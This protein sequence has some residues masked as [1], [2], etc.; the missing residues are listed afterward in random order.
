MAEA[1]DLLAEGR[2]A[3]E[4]CEAAETEN[5]Q[6][7]RDDV[8]FA[9]E[10]KQWPDNIEKQRIAEGRPVI[11]VSKL[12]AFIRQVVNDARQNKPSVKVQPV[13]SGADIETA[14]VIAGLIRNIESVSNADI[15]YDTG[16]EC[17]VSRG[18]GYW[19]VTADH[20]YDD[21]FD[22]DLMIRRVPNPDTVYGDPSSTEADSSDWDTA[23]VVDW[24]KEAQF[25]RDWKGKNKTNFSADISQEQSWARDN[26]GKREIQV[27]EWWKR[28]KIDKP[29]VQVRDKRD[30]AIYVYGK[31]QLETDSDL[32]MLKQLGQLEF[33]NERVTKSCKVIQRFM[34][35][36]EILETKDWPGRYIPIV[37]VYG[38]D[39]VDSNGKRQLRGLIHSA[40]DAQRMFN[41]WRTTSTELVA[42]APR[43]PYIG[44]VG[45]FATDGRWDSV[46][47]TSHPYV[48]YDGLVAPQRQPLDTGAAAGALQEALNAADDIKA[49]IGM[50]DA[51][52]GARSNETSGKAIMA[53]QREGDVATFHFNDNTSRAIRHTGRIL[54]D[55][56]P[57]YYSAERVVRIL[58]EDGKEQAIQINKEFQKTDPRSGQPMM[59]PDGNGVMQPVMAMHDLRVGKY[60]VAVSQGPSFTTRR[61]EAAEAMT[62]MIRA[63]PQSAPVIGP[64]LA[65]NLDFP[66][67]EE[68]ADE[69]KALASGQPSPEIQKMIE[70]GK[71]TI[72]KQAGEIEQLNQQLAE[73]KMDRSVDQEK[74][75]ADIEAENAKA[76]ADFQIEQI[77]I[78]SQERIAMAKIESEKRI[79]MA[80][81]AMQ[82]QVAANRPQPAQAA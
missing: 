60:D 71:Q 31:D 3:F 17:A 56:I 55:L 50:F 80:K 8:S 77:R 40:I 76:A 1:D 18:R 32:V 28:E 63:F 58:G 37:P 68:I 34:S 59:Q 75:Q 15:A 51:S 9:I 38:E 48:E 70:Q 21:S 12:K 39:Y 81:A 2:E 25:D 26:G 13:D 10:E 65:K 53:R 72:E 35:G 43:V 36:S 64:R 52:L 19:R 41:Y 7:G 6:V 24:V 67:A 44:P 62:E 61:Q 46:N 45:A 78:A 74:L 20:A 11:T 4:T 73:A 69:L 14:K 29:I 54:V 47:T 49:A 33:M 27:A 23:F 66:E 57:H 79:N 42:L 5:R 16:N 82:A 30:G 22:M